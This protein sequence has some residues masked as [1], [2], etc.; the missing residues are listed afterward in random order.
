MRWHVVDPNGGIPKAFA[1]GE[2]RIAQATGRMVEAN[3][4]LVMSIATRHLHRGMDLPD[5]LQ[6]GCIGLMRAVEKFDYRRGFKFSTYATW[7]IRQAVRRAIVDRL[8]KDFRCARNRTVAQRSA[9]R[10]TAAP[11]TGSIVVTYAIL[12]WLSRKTLAGPME[13]RIDVPPLS[14]IGKLTGYGICAM[15]LLMMVASTLHINLI[16]PTILWLHELRRDGVEIGARRFL[17]IGAAVTF[18]ALI[19]TLMPVS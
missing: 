10:L 17:C 19:G 9:R 13:S 8:F 18:P 4:R 7:W 14:P 11:S 5:L 3:L 6:E 16:A 15:A 2:A 12:R 1:Q